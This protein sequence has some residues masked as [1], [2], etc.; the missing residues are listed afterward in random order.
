GAGAGIRRD[1][2]GRAR[3]GNPRPV[4][5]LVARFGTRH[6]VKAFAVVLGIA[7]RHVWNPN[8]NRSPPTRAVRIHSG[9]LCPNDPSPLRRNLP[10]RR[11]IPHYKGQL[12]LLDQS[13]RLA[14]LVPWP[15]HTG[16][17]AS[18]PPRLGTMLGHHP[19]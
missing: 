2:G 12:C 19:G 4:E 7:A 8:P 10:E 18:R 14:V 15:A 9:S 16:P 3:S 13:S 11:R 6:V 17:V 1:L 5:F